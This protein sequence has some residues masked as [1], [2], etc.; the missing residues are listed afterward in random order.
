MSQHVLTA[1]VA[2]ETES[3]QDLIFRG[4]GDRLS[5]H[6]QCGGWFCATEFLHFGLIEEPLIRQ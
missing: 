1:T 4:V 5:I 3:I 2:T 6:V